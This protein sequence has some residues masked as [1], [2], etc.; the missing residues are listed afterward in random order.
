MSKMSRLPK[1][2]KITKGCGGLLSRL[3]NYTKS[4]QGL[5]SFTFTLSVTPAAEYID[6]NI[7]TVVSLTHPLRR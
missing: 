2:Y 3:Q 1:I 4:T 5:H 7:Y 6:A